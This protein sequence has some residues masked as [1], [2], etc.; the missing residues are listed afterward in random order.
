MYE[1]GEKSHLEG[2]L[3]TVQELCYDSS[4]QRLEAVVVL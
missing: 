4:S 1:W 3:D 2:V